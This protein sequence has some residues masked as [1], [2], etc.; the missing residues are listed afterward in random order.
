MTVVS[1]M[2]SFTLRI[3]YL[4][5]KTLKPSNIKRKF[6]KQK[7]KSKSRKHVRNAKFLALRPSKF[8]RNYNPKC[9][10]VINKKQNKV[11]TIK[12]KKNQS[13]LRF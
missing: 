5:K 12:S 13:D 4:K 3:I 10:E 2:Q 7:A 1:D 9:P 8:L 6:L 11:M